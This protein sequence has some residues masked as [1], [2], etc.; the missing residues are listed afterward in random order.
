M[1]RCHS[2]PF[3]AEPMAGGGVRFRLWAPGVNSV[4]LRLDEA[5]ELP[6]LAASDGWFE[7]QV[8]TAGTGSRYQFCLPDGLRVPDPASRF[9]PEGV[10]SASEVID[11]TDFDWPGDGWRGRPWEEAVIYELH[12]GSFTR[13]GSFAGVMERLDYLVELGVTAIEL[14]PVAA[15][16]GRRNWGYDGVL[17]FAPDASYGRPEDFK[18]LIAAAHQRG[19]MVLLDVVYNHFGPDGNYLH[20]YAPAF[21]NPLHV[22][23]WGAAI[24]FDGEGSP[25]VRDFFIQN[26]LYWLEEYA[27]D[28]LRLDAIHAI[29]DDS[30]PDIVE[31][32]AAAL[33]QGPGRERQVHLVLE[34]DRNQ[35]RY[36]GRYLG[37][38]G[39]GQ[40][41]QATAQWN[42][43]LQHALHVLASAESDGYFVDYAAEPLGLLGRCLTEGFAFQ[44]DP[45]PFR[46]NAL[47]GEPS[48]HLPPGAFVSFLQNHD[49]VGNRA[50]GE[51]LSQLASPAALEAVTALLLLAPQ[52]PL[53]FMGEEFAAAQPFLFFCDFAGELASAVTAGRR[54]E[55]ASFGRFADPAERERIPDPNAETTFAACVLDWS[56][57]KRPPHLAVLQLHRRLLALRRQW[58]APR[59]ARMG[60][61]EPRLTLL[62]A[63]ALTVRWRL[64]DGSR[65]TLAANL[66]EQEVPLA[67]ETG[68][69]IF[70]TSQLSPALLAAGRLPPWSVAWHLHD[71]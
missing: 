11:P 54:S 69:L 28:G 20:A 63:R 18:R 9:N 27:L 50:F 39:D 51:R 66:G 1:K 22:T 65:L 32:L 55:F 13:A 35:A 19:L 67:P 2:M 60:N 29:C 64:G 14:M 36:L 3:G 57:L 68:N 6:M 43:D 16:P 34:N 46:D 53:L 31:E 8:K 42:D 4:S 48:S 30:V 71:G 12:V 41:R 10:H 58:L 33:R 24:N 26:A 21:F 59:L 15:F 44:G 17:P 38:D 23:P 45:S 49:Q 37:Q 70:F 25:T 40:P 7:L 56:A 61:G 47:R 52:A 5:H 62:S